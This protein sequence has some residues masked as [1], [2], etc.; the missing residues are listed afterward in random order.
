V[1]REK[2]IKRQAV[3]EEALAEVNLTEETHEVNLTEETHK[4]NLTEE[5]H[6]GNLTDIQERL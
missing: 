3:G 6:E 2:C 4:G 1:T 5:T